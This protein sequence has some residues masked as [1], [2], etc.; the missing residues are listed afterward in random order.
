MTDY[1]GLCKN[2]NDVFDHW[3]LGPFPIWG[4][5]TANSRLGLGGVCGY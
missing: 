4:F 2:G 1:F 3:M 5:G